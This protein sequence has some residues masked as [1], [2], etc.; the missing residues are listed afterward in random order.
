MASLIV[1][2]V[3]VVHIMITFQFPPGEKN[4]NYYL[5]KDWLTW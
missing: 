3:T 4:Q 1:I 5:L 2:F